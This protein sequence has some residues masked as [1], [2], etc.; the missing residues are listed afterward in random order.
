MVH[1]P[2][3]ECSFLIPIRRDASL[4]DG[5]E[6]ERSLWPWLDAELYRQFGGGYQAEGFYQGFYKDPDTGERVSDRCLKYFVAMPESQVDQL[7]QL[8]QGVCDL[9]QQKCVY[10]NVA[11]H[12][13]FV[14]PSDE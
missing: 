8:L 10:L 9:F 12:V 7:R 4:S 5:K 3:L 1:D 11:G 6:H 13:E 14:R 2:P